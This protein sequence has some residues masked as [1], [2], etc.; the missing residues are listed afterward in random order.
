MRCYRA[1]QSQFKFKHKKK[2]TKLNFFDV[3]EKNIRI[4]ILA[5]LLNDFEVK[6]KILGI[7]WPENFFVKFI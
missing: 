6:R 3:H 4:N 7:K 5:S 2:K 1:A